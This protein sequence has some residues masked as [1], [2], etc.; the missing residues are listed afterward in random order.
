MT[1]LSDLEILS[2]IISHLAHDVGH[3]GYT[4]RFLVNFRD[5]LAI[6]CNKYIDNDISVL[7]NMHCCLTFSLL[8]EP[9]KNVLESLEDDQ[10][11]IVRKLIIEL[12]LATD[13]GKHFEFVGIFKSKYYSSENFETLEYKLD[14]LKMLIKAADIGHAAKKT[15]IHSNWSFLICEEFFRQGDIE[16]DSG[17]SISMY[18]NR[19][20]TVISKSQIGFLKNI[21][22]PVYETFNICLNCKL[23]ENNCIEQIK[24]NIIYLENQYALTNS[25]SLRERNSIFVLPDL[26]P[27]SSAYKSKS[28]YMPSR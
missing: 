9:D 21:A 24:S 22:L 13:M 1:K 16:R 27:I 17:K 26:T 3:P 11:I 7:E 8:S 10:Y 18:C 4:N 25:I 14:I 5:Q 28:E 6:K 2:I 12:I 23:F 15:D 19:E 20:T